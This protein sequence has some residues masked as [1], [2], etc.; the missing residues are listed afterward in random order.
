MNWTDWF[1]YKEGELYWLKNVSNK[2]ENSIA[3]GLVNTGY[4]RVMIHN[5]SYAVHRVIWEIL[6]GPILDGYQ[7]DHINHNRADNRIENLRLATNKQNNQNKS[8][9]KDS[10]TK[11]KGVYWRQD[12]K[13]YR[14]KIK[15]NGKENHLGYFDTSEEASIAYQ[16]A[17]KKLH[18]EF[19]CT[20]S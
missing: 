4:R 14:A 19:S 6:K 8:V 18:G 1:Y 12:T 2:K 3:G 17:S 7:I 16:E 9:R 11:I 10:E 13:K 15:I 20:T 5:K